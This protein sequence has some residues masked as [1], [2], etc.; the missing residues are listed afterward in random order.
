M[1]DTNGHTG[2][3]A[4]QIEDDAEF[5][6]LLTE[7]RQEFQ[8]AGPTENYLVLQMTTAYWKA[9]R[10]T[11]LET[12]ALTH[13]S[14]LARPAIEPTAHP[15]LDPE[16]IVL[17]MAVHADCSHGNVLVKLTNCASIVDRAFHRALQ[18]LERCQAGRDSQPAPKAA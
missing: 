8:P 14:D 10:L 18:Q 9:V 16:T 1:S 13:E 12:G 7:F 17:G 6:R 11:R 4:G 15:T 3:T 2:R 5:N